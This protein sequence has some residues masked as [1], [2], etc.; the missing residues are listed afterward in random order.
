[1]SEE[2]I[3]FKKLDESAI[4]PTKGTPSAVG[5]DLYALK[6]VTVVGGAGC[7]LIPTG[8]AVQLPEHTYGRIAMRSGLAVKQHLS[9]SAGVIDIDYSGGLGVVVYCTKTHNLLG[10]LDVHTY[11][12]KKGEK[13]AQLIPEKA[14]YASSQSVLEF[15]RQYDQH[16]GYGSTGNG[17][18]KAK[19]WISF[20]G[21]LM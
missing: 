21:C 8:I 14:S 12:I 11:T 5:Y 17:F 2:I 6:D 1:M 13:F 3:Q 18:K 15:V 9:V 4:I 20:F 7:V 19:E 16:L 10:E